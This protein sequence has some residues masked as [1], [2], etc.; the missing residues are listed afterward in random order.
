M[1][2]SYRD[3]TSHVA[4]QQYNRV[5]KLAEGAFAE[6]WP[7]N[8]GRL[9]HTSR[10]PTYADCAGIRAFSAVLECSSGARAACENTPRDCSVSALPHEAL[11]GGVS[12]RRDFVE[13]SN[14]SLMVECLLLP[15]CCRVLHQQRTPVLNSPVPDSTP[16]PCIAVNAARRYGLCKTNH[17]G[18]NL[19]SRSCS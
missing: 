18:S 11:G 3:L 4:W 14:D 12:F 16:A 6:V 1:A 17:R 19:R 2:D 7:R 8:R 10:I 9:L 15:H 5:E 13:V